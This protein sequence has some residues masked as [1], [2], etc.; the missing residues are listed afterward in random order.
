MGRPAPPQADQVAHGSKCSFVTVRYA[1]GAVEYRYE[2]AI[3][4]VGERFGV[5]TGGV[6]T[7]VD[8]T[9]PDNAF[10]YVDDEPT[11]RA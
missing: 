1:S 11:P 6:V 7:H 5:P 9:D 2:V 8:L 10:V 3:P 4:A